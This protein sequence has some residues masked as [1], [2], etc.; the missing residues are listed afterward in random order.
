M[1]SVIE[2]KQQKMLALVGAHCLSFDAVTA[3]MLVR[4]RLAIVEEKPQAETLERLSAL[5][6]RLADWAQSMADPR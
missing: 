4:L 2:D 1:T 3:M 5:E 6:D